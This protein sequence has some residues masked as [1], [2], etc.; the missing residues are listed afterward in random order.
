M[1]Q[2]FELFK[3]L[4]RYAELVL[5]AVEGLN[6]PLLRFPATAGKKACPEHCR[7]EIGLKRLERLELVLPL[8]NA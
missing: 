1:T 6:L 3:S 5:K 7:R 4:N 8:G 2:A